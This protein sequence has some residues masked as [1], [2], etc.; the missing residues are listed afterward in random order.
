MRKSARRLQGNVAPPTNRERIS[1]LMHKYASRQHAHFGLDEHAQPECPNMATATPLG[2]PGPRRRRSS[3]PGCSSW[4]RNHPPPESVFPRAR[5]GRSLPRCGELAFRTA[6]RH[7]APDRGPG[8]ILIPGGGAAGDQRA[9]DRPACPA[10]AATRRLRAVPVSTTSWRYGLRRTCRL[11]TG[12]FTSIS[13]HM[14]IP[15]PASA[16][17]G[18]AP[19]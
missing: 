19:L 18:H 1:R 11:V 10:M 9:Q 15:G 16:P 13:V 17:R 8:R 12:R 7:R 5:H 14:A 2:P 3:T 4:T 6:P